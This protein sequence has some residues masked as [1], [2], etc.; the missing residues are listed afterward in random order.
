ME[1]FKISSRAHLLFSRITHQFFRMF[2]VRSIHFSVCFQWGP[3]SLTSVQTLAGPYP[4]MYPTVYLSHASIHCFSLPHLFMLP[5]PSTKPFKKPFKKSLGS[6]ANFFQLF[7]TTSN[8]LQLLQIPPKFSNNSP[9]FF[10]KKFPN[11]YKSII[12]YIFPFIYFYTP[13]R[14]YT[15]YILIIIHSAYIPL[16]L[17]HC[18]ILCYINL[19]KNKWKSLKIPI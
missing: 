13:Y 3:K 6:T 14:I 16:S 15:K 5:E 7:P 11:F 12:F 19:Y 17:L 9:N 1:I 8:F 4:P 18:I 10:H 2:L